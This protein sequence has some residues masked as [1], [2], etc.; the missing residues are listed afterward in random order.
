M[1]VPFG[2]TNCSVIV[3]NF[4]DD[5]LQDLSNVGDMLAVSFF[6]S[7]RTG[8]RPNNLQR[9]NENGDW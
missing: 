4:D 3:S 7:G 9:G 2:L 8:I 1:V 5:A 6:M